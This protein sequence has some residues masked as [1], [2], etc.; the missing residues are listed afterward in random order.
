[1]NWKRWLSSVLFAVSLLTAPT[2]TAAATTFQWVAPEAIATYYTTELNSLADGSFVAVG[3]AIAN[4]SGLYQYIDLEIVL[5]SLSP[6][7]GAYIDVWLDAT[8]DGTNYSDAG[9][10]LQTSSLLCTVQL[11]TA[12]TTAQRIVVRNLTIPPLGFKLQLRNKS[13]VALG[14]SGNTLKYRRHNEQGI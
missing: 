3:S 9:K 14:A 2:V 7:A 8:L 12:S 4:E 13:G 10:A 6:A 5:A 11:D 1:M